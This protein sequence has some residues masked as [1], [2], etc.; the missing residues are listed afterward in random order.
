MTVSASSVFYHIEQNMEHL[1]T[2]TILK[3]FQAEER[4][5]FSSWKFFFHLSCLQAYENLRRV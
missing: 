2:V 5:S 3:D 1:R 4:F